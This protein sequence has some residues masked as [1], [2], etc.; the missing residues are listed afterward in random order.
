MIELHSANTYKQPSELILEFNQFSGPSSVN[1]SDLYAPH[2]NINASRD[3]SYNRALYNT[4]ESDDIYDFD[5]TS[6]DHMIP[7]SAIVND[8]SNGYS[9]TDED[10]DDE[11]DINFDY[12]YGYDYERVIKDRLAKVNQDFVNDSEPPKRKSIL[13]SFDA[14]VTAIDIPIEEQQKQ[15]EI[16]FVN[17]E[18]KLRFRAAVSET[19]V[20]EN[21]VIKL[22][23]NDTVQKE[24]PDHFANQV[25]IK[26]S[27]YDAQVLEL[28]QG[29][30]NS[31]RPP[32]QS[33]DIKSENVNILE[34]S[35][36]KNNKTDNDKASPPNPVKFTNEYMSSTP[37]PP[38]SD[39]P[40][41]TPTSEQT[42]SNN[43]DTNKKLIDNYENSDWTDS[44]S[45]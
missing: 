19:D 16:N 34:P 21:N 26:N 45:R 1:R 23:L 30:N 3:M 22:P 33:G 11:D 36:Q 37:S 24:D 41:N 39:N 38:P 44:S 17:A 15:N 18:E 31:D 29:N 42:T 6:G 28:Q 4:N 35:R 10:D 9:Y 8:P 27:M 13:V 32:S 12:E 40:S 2:T 43:N 25:R 5:S 7:Q 14:A 20:E